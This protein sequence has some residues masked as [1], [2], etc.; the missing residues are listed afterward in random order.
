VIEFVTSLLEYLD[1]EIC[2]YC[3]LMVLNTFRVTPIYSSAM[4]KCSGTFTSTL[5][6]SVPL[7]I[8]K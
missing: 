2:K 5:D 7:S 8:M 4:F 3:A 6:L 1:L